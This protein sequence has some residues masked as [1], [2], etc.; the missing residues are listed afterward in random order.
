[1]K[2]QLTLAVV[3]ALVAAA[4]ACSLSAA[5]LYVALDSPNPTP[6]YATW[7]TAAT[8]IQDAVDAAQAGDAV[9]VTNGVYAVGSREQPDV[10]SSRVVV[11]NAIRLES[12]NGPELSVNHEWHGFHGWKPPVRPSAIR[13]F[14]VM[15]HSSLQIRSP[16]GSDLRAWTALSPQAFT[17][18]E[19]LDVIAIIAVLAGML[20]PALSKAR[21]KAQLGETCDR[22]AGLDLGPT[23]STPIALSLHCN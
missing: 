12:V 1:M 6:P 16:R 19:L 2:I 4:L 7:A 18:I 15:R 14:P 21:C 20:L 10:G 22:T 8:N 11:T 9:L 5:T 13:G 23:S 17:L 3:V